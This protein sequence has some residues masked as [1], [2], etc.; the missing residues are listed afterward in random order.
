MS[1]D[2]HHIFFYNK[3]LHARVNIKFTITSHIYYDVPG[4]KKNNSK[5]ID[6]QI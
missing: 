2:K 3:H 6:R 4:N 1:V 5:E